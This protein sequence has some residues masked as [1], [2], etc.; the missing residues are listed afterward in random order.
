M[1]ALVFCIIVV[2]L[3]W[4]KLSYP[5][6]NLKNKNEIIKNLK[7]SITNGFCTCKL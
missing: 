4:D 7:C 3:T 1:K 2:I 5:P 6:I